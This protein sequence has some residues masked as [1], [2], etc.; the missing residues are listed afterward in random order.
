MSILALDAP[1]LPRLLN[2]LSLWMMNMAVPECFN[3]GE[4]MTKQ[5]KSRLKLVQFLLYSLYIPYEELERLEVDR[6][7]QNINCKA[8]LVSQGELG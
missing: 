2:R 4:T 7:G 5:S 6:C 1:T 8:R 3:R